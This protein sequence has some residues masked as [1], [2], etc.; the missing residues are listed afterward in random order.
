MIVRGR[1]LVFFES[2]VEDLENIEEFI[3]QYNKEKALKIPK[4]SGNL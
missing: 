2:F 1:E 3:R 4:K